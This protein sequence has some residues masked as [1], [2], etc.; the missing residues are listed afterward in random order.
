MAAKK[1]Q[2]RKLQCESG[3]LCQHNAATA[4]AAFISRGCRRVK[5]L[6]P[7]DQYGGG[8][9]TWNQ[10]LFPTVVV[11]PVARIERHLEVIDHHHCRRAAPKDKFEFLGERQIVVPMSVEVEEKGTASQRML[12]PGKET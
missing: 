1:W 3:V 12:P 11:I 5:C 2:R 10:R 4:R 7:V 6:Q 8:D 9:I